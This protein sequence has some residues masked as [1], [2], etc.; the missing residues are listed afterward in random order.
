[1]LRYV[2]KRLLWLIPV[3]IGVITIVFLITAITPGDPIA[4]LL[5]KEATEA[6][7]EALRHQLGLDLPLF[8]RWVNY[9]IGV[10]TRFDFG[11]SYQT[12]QPIKGE[13]LSHLPVTIL[14][15]VFGVSFGVL[16]GL[17][18]GIVAS[19]KQYTWIDS[20]ALVFSVLL[21]SIPNFW[22]ALMLLKVFAVDLHWLPSF[23]ITRITG[24]VL[25]ILV[26]GLGSTTFIARISRSS[27]L[28]VMRE[29]YIRTARAKGQRES[30]TVTRHMLRNAMIPI[31]TSV[32]SGLGNSLGGNMAIE[33]VF[34]LPGLG[35]YV[36]LAIAGRN[37]PSML[38]GIL[39]IS[40]MFTLINLLV[41]LSYVAI[42][43]RL[44]TQLFKKRVKR[45]NLKKMIQQQGVT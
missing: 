5:S 10:F 8:T 42:D 2:V 17:P 27:M 1:M 43:P 13:L 45:K 20:A 3:V 19:L 44:K 33:A 29:D 41:D 12:G 14:L 31:V 36:V 34:A 7:R 39:V 18:L 22:L 4:Q 35:N 40:I 37:Y 16:T 6:Q 30:V 23:G 15:A 25:P 38:G 28:Q 24:W 21:F 32:G 9:V 11:L 26:A